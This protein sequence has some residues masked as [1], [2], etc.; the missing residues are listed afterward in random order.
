M[1]PSDPRLRRQL[2]PARTQLLGV[3]AGGLASSALIIVQA[4]TITGL[5]VAALG[6]RR[7]LP[8][9]IATGAVLALRGV[10]ALVSDAYAAH[11]AA[12]VGSDLRRR[13]VRAV[14]AGRPGAGGAT[15]VL[16]TR[17]VAA[18]EPYLTRYLPTLVLATVL[19]LLTVVV[20]AT[21]DLLSALIVV[22]TLPLVPVFGA[23]VGLATRD[24]AQEQWQ[25]MGSLAG[26]FLDVMRGLPTLVAHRRAR[27]QSA[28]IAKIT[29][30]YRR[31][32]M[33]TLRLAFAS[34][35]VLELVATLSVALVAVTVG[36]RL[37]SGSL[38]LSTALV[39]LLLAP[40][41]YWPLR[42]V[43]AEFHAA[44]EGSA[45]FEAVDALVG[46]HDEDPSGRTVADRA[47]L[48]L[49]DLS[50]VHPGRTRPALAGLSATL[51]GRG[52]TVV[53]GPSGCGKSTLLSALAGLVPGAG[54][55]ILADGVPVGGIR[56]Q[57][58]VAWLPQRPHFVAG[59][60]A[61]NLRLG[62]PGA[63][64]DALWEAL[65]RVALEERVRALPRGLEEPLG[66][67]GAT[68]SAG[69]R[70]R[71][72]LARVVVADRPWTLLDEPTAHLD[73]LTE[74]IIADTIVDLGRRGAVVV[75]AHRPAIVALADHVLAL[76]ARAP[77]GGTPSPGPV[78]RTPSRRPAPDRLPTPPPAPAS[79]R[80]LWGSALLGGLASTAGVALTAT[81]GWLIVQ[82]STRP[83]ILTLLVAIVGVRAFGLARPVLR[84]AE[85]LLSHDAALRL[86][87][88]RRVQVYDAMVPL[89]PARL[90]RRRGDLLASV[91]DDVDSVVDQELRVRLPVRSFVIV[92]AIATTVA[93]V[94]LPWIGVVV[95]VTCLLTGG[96]AFAAAY[97]GARRA[98]RATVAL[99]AELSEAVVEVVQLAPELRMWQA[100]E[101]AARRVGSLSDGLGR[102]TREAGRR[103][104]GARALVLGVTGVAVGATAVL[105]GTA[106]DAGTLSGPSMALLVLL[107]LALVDV[108]LPLAD[109][110]ALSARTRA[111][112]LRLHRLE[113][114]APAVRDTVAVATPVTPETELDAV[115]G[116]W[117]ADAPLTSAVSLRLTPG[118]RVALVGP[119]GSGKSTVAALLLRF[120][121]PTRGRVTMGGHDT[122]LMSLDDVRTVTGLVDDDPHVFATTVVEN[123][124][125]AR[126]DATDPQVEAA[127]RRACLGDWLDSLPDGLHTWLGDGHAGVSGGERARLAV[128]RSVLADQPVLILDEP[129]AH[130]DHAT[131][132]ELAADVLRDDPTR[133]VLWITHGDVGLD[134]VD[135][136]V[137]IPDADAIRIGTQSVGS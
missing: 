5:V 67:D 86:L 129:A 63:D 31:A 4:F 55:E 88:R 128:A 118:S 28:R 13:I 121:D 49:R 12:V 40:E 95:G 99:R 54:G 97:L 21:Q 53:T 73:Q 126:P 133:S 3:L 109:A 116:R 77:A 50:V 74:Q 110:G 100:G 36:V 122:R 25:A 112:G 41:A 127:L 107:P 65:S 115:C 9:A 43:G 89:T 76:P 106:V 113:R 1:K 123:V 24:R 82:A 98:E 134:L 16:A 125:F 51:P 45:T 131:A 59:S 38:D 94:L 52:V 6:D 102:A 130:L 83:A 85:R 64:D 57:A 23:L 135:H 91:V 29:D 7:V 39:V 103:L 10:A 75:V 27:A 69:E 87:A 44:A 68:L 20:I 2:A 56:W 19:P 26:H 62:S 15:A 47:P 14:V 104:G 37:A 81:A 22:C 111:A 137:T 124:R 80:R 136:V 17:G 93:T 119:S 42:R 35:A 70:A 105:G 8:W 30:R 66:E 79:Y 32:S 132:I 117:S 108:A 58:Q 120:L 60:V 71:L 78:P 61:D 34:S 114:T 90:G 92:G 18:A 11:A 48:V 101:R 72:A 84:Y 96:G 33:S 46:E